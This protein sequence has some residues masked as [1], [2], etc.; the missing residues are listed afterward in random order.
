MA[1][2]NWLVP[3]ILIWT[4]F[5]TA[6]QRM[7]ID[8]PTATGSR[9]FIMYDLELER[10]IRRKIESDER[11]RS[12]IDVIAKAAKNEVTLS[13]TVPSEAAR[14]KAVELAKSAHSGLIIN[15]KIAVKPAV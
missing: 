13:G 7:Y 5:F 4:L 11:L 1:H 9:T 12:A 14:A 8:Q 15:D 3:A 2:I 6:D 10:S